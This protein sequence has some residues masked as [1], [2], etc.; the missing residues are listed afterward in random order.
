VRGGLEKKNKKFS[1]D[2]RRRT[3]IHEAGKITATVVVV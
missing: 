1:E 2:D 3:A